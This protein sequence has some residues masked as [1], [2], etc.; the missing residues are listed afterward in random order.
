[1][2]SDLMK[3][4]DRTNCVIIEGR[5]LS[6]VTESFSHP[7]PPSRRLFNPHRNFLCPTLHLACSSLRHPHHP[8]PLSLPPH[9]YKG[10]P[11]LH[12]RKLKTQVHPHHPL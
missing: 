10:P 6:K 1:D 7:P 5:L 12:S 2:A 11:P 4:R 3:I 8:H 9:L